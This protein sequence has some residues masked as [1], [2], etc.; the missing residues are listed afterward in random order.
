[1]T[2]CLPNNFPKSQIVD[3]YQF[4]HNK[5]HS[6]LVLDYGSLVNHHKSPNV[7]AAMISGTIAKPAP[8][9][10]FLVRITVF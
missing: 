1:M 2:L 3:N 5:T 4:G 7:K 6:A 8:N 10:H 9:I